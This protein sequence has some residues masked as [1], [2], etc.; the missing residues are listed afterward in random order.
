LYCFYFRSGSFKKN[1][2]AP[3][4]RKIFKNGVQ[5]ASDAPTSSTTVTSIITVGALWT[6]AGQLLGSL[7]EIRL[8][9][10]AFTDTQL[11]DAWRNIFLDANLEF[12]YKF[13][14]AIG[15]T[16][17]YD[18][19]NNNRQLTFAGTPVLE[20]D[21][22]NCITVPTT[23]GQGQID[24]GHQKFSS[25]NS[26]ASSHANNTFIVNGDF[27]FSFYVKR[28]SIGTNMWILN[29]GAAPGINTYLTI[30]Y[31]ATNQFTFSF[32][33]ANTDLT[34]VST[35]TEID[36]WTRKIKQNSNPFY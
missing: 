20:D 8:Y 28:Y 22:S 35:H 11:Y 33:N 1:A 4:I 5:I 6:N 16:T 15:S 10:R 12:Y 36:E 31:R 18:Y 17:I 24:D 13:N 21:G 23:C 3:H 34:T 19:S 7:D 30:G 27:S 2:T 14:E 9:S 29:I 26:F 25:T 32:N